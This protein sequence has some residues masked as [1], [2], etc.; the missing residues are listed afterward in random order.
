VIAIGPTKL[1]I[2]VIMFLSPFA[3]DDYC[4]RAALSSTFF[5]IVCVLFVVL[6]PPW[7]MRFASVYG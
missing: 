2:F 4:T 6:M 7:A 5:L 1:V 3:L